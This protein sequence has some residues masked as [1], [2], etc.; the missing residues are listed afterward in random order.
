MGEMGSAPQ[1][2]RWIPAA[3]LVGLASSYVLSDLLR[4]PRGWF[5]VGH[6]VLVGAL[7]LGYVWW[8][9]LGIRTQLA[10]RRLAGAVGGILIG[11]FLAR[12]VLRQPAARRTESSSVSSRFTGRCMEWSM[13]CCCR[14]SRSS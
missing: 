14:S 2:T 12:Q 8:E 4:F 13:R 11:A 6:A 9:R 5:V 3:A 10:R 1:V 7:C